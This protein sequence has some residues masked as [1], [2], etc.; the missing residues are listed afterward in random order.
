MVLPR[1]KLRGLSFVNVALVAIVLA[2]ALTAYFLFFKKDPPAASATRPSVAVQRGE[3]TASVSSSGTLQS[4]QTASPQF[5]TSGTVTQVLVKVGQVVAKGAAIAKV[6][7]AAA[8]RQLRI[9]QQNQIASA[10]SVTAAEETL[11][12]AQEALEA[13]EEAS[14]SPSPT[15]TPSDGQQQQTQQAQQSQGQGQSQSPEVAVS[16]AEASLAKAK[17]DKEQSDQNVEAAQAAVDATTL[18][19]PIAGTITAINGAVGSVAGGSS[20]NSSSG[21]A[22]QGST[23]GQGSVSTST[24]ATTSGTGF[25][26][27]ADLKSLQVVAAFPEADAIK[28]KAGQTATVT[29]NAE[30]GTTLTASLATVSPTPTT[31]NGVVSYS[32]TFS[33]AKLP[34]N[35]RMGQTANVTVQTAK[36]ANAL[37]VPSTAIATSG[38]TYTVTMADGSGT[39]EVQVGVRGD[40]YTQI[41]S[42]LNEGDQVELLQGAIGGTGTQNGQNRQGQQP[43]G[44]QF[45]GQ[46]VGQGAGGFR[47]R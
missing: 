10:N 26:D 21:S 23:S 15:P 22:G 42:G 35:A 44:G 34:A 46:G 25:V 12:D 6:D 18:K 38:T 13:A 8:E 28:I 11:S 30:P 5:E 36:A 40:S 41:T 37:Y 16:N 31:T 32:A 43:G 29:L 19:A 39:R 3:V 33:L 2:I 1:H 7:P 24:S 4:S 45:P 47:G 9:A 20:S 17:A 27:M 14:A